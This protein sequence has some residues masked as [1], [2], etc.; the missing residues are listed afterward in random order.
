MIKNGFN[1]SRIELVEGGY[2][3]GDGE[4][5]LEFWFVPKDSDIPKPKPDAFPKKNE[6]N[7]LVLCG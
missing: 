1:G 2:I 5:R 6:A 3:S 4:R 7:N